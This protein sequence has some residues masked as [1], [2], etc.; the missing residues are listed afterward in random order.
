MPKFSLIVAT[1]PVYYGHD[2]DILSSCIWENV[3]GIEVLRSVE[4]KRLT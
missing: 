2:A 3:Y 1:D 4:L